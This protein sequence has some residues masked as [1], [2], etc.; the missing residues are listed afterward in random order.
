MMEMK[1]KVSAAPGNSHL[2]MQKWKWK[3]DDGNANLEKYNQL[4]VH[5]LEMNDKDSGDQREC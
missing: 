3:W 4:S 2:S 5:M 1:S